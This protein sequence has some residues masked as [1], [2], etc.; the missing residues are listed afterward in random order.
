M[1]TKGADQPRRDSPNRTVAG[2][3]AGVSCCFRAGGHPDRPGGDSLFGVGLGIICVLHRPRSGN[4][5]APAE[6][7][8]V[9]RVVPL[10]GPWG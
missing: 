2:D 5:A 7:E 10:V 3:S 4:H 9:Y 6:A 1:E 8:G